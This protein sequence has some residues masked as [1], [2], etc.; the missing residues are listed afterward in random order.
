MNH[1]EALDKITALILNLS[2]SKED[3]YSAK[4]HVIGCNDCLSELDDIMSV[5]FGEPVELRT[6]VDKLIKCHEIENLLPD[7]VNGIIDHDSADYTQIVQHLKECDQCSFKKELITNLLEETERELDLEAQVKLFGLEL[8]QKT[9]QVPLWQK[10]D[11]GF[12][13]LG[14]DIKIFVEENIAKFLPIPELPQ[15]SFS[16]I[17]IVEP[18]MSRSLRGATKTKKNEIRKEKLAKRTETRLPLQLVEIPDQDSDI[19]IQIKLKDMKSIEVKLITLSQSTKIENAIISIIEKSRD[20]I[21][22]SKLTDQEGIVI[23]HK[24]NFYTKPDYM[25]RILFNA[26]RWEISFS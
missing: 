9:I 24:L 21:L 18:Q 8:E 22:F 1:N 16:E 15:L 20:E 12:K 2:L 19:L 4:L 25:I 26:K 5:L 3:I 23:F 14:A 6:K 7:F 11:A 10:I 13:K 17:P